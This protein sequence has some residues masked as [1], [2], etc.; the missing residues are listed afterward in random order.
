MK[1]LVLSHKQTLKNCKPYMFT[2]FVQCAHSGMALMSK[3]AISKGMNPYVFVVYRQAFASLALAPFAFIDRFFHTF[4]ILTLSPSLI[5]PNIYIY[6]CT[7]EAN[8]TSHKF[9]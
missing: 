8:L 2:I 7:L 4:C 6:I 9:D 3:A 1:S 5:P